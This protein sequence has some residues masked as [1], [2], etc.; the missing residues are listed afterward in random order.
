MFARSLTIA[1]A[2][3][4]ASPLTAANCSTGTCPSVYHQPVV[5]HN[6][7]TP[8]VEP[9]TTY[10]TPTIINQTIFYEVGHDVR[11]PAVA[12][13]AV[14]AAE[15]GQLKR[16]SQRIQ[17]KMQDLLAYQQQSQPQ[18][19]QIVY[20]PVPQQMPAQP[21]QQQPVQQPACA[22]GSKCNPQPAPQPPTSKPTFSLKAQ[23]GVV[24]AKCIKCHGG[25]GEPKGDLDLRGSI[26]CEQYHEAMKRLLTDDDSQRMPKGQPP[27]TPEETA[28]AMKQLT[29][30]VVNDAK[31]K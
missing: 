10:A 28:E 25:S 14:I 18:Q 6:Y 9:V 2:F 30:M 13:Q 26:T 20:V 24:E 22:P 3:L 19:P 11:Y 8:Y 15:V 23:G 29:A 31:G 21:V 16:E 27:L 17:D 7:V 1:L 5:S 12:P 4:M